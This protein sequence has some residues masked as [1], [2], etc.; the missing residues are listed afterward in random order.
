[1]FNYLTASQASEI[2]PVLRREGAHVQVQRV[3]HVELRVYIAA[4]YPS[5]CVTA[6]SSNTRSTYN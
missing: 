4:V 6:N 3:K 5:A 2:H 1:M